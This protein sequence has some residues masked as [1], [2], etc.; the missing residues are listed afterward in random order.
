LIE[1]KKKRF[2]TRK[3]LRKIKDICCDL[4]NFRSEGSLFDAI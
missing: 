2:E 1:K 4:S 3:K